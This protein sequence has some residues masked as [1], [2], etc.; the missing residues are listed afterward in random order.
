MAYYIVN[1]R[2]C[3]IAYTSVYLLGVIVSCFE[4]RYSPVVKRII[5]RII[6]CLIF[7]SFISNFVQTISG[8]FFIF[9]D[10]FPEEGHG[11]VITVRCFVTIRALIFA[12]AF[13]FAIIG[14]LDGVMDWEEDRDYQERQDLEQAM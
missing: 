1:E 6:A 10:E 14:M 4:T 12:L 3:N 8:F 11:L 9:S 7:T 5:Y 2:T 13:S